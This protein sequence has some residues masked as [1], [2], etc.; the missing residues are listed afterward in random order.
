MDKQYQ[1]KKVEAKIYSFWEKK[2]FFS[3]SKSKKK[4]S[5]VIPPPN[6]TGSLHMGHAL[7]TIIQDVLIRWK[8]MEGLKTIWVPAIDHAG[9]ATQN[10][11][12]KQLKKEGKTRFDLGREKF[13]KRVWKWK[14]E[15]GDKILKQLKKFGASCDWSRTRFTM[16]KEYTQAVMKAFSHYYDKGWIYRKKRVVNWCPRCKT[17]LSDLEVE[18]KEEKGKLW[19]IKYLLVGEKEK[20]L[21]VATTRPETLLGDTAV[22]V[23]PKD[24]R[25]K[26]LVGKKV[27]LPIVNKEIPVIKDFAVDPKFGTGVV[28]I[29]PAHDLKDYQVSQRH[30]LELVQVIDEDGRLNENAPASYRG[31]KAKEAREK[32]IEDLNKSNLIEKTEDYLHQIPICYRCKFLLEPLPS[33][34]W[35][36]KMDKLAEMAKKAIRSKK[37]RFHPERW[38]RVSLSWLEE[39]ND[40]CISRQIWWGHRIPVWYCEN[41]E[42]SI[43]NLPL[44]MGFAGDIIPQVFDNK[45]R[46]Y[47]IRDYNF[48]KGDKVAFIDRSIGKTFGFGIITESVKTTV[49]KLDLKDKKHW[50]AYNSYEELIAA[51]KRHFPDREIK[52]STPVCIYTYKF[53][54]TCEPFVS[55]GTAPSK[56]R[57]CGSKKLKQVEDVFDTWFSSALWPFV[58]FGWPGKV[59]DFYPTDTLSTARDIIFLW[60]ARMIFSGLE[61]TKEVPFRDVIVHAIVLTKEGKRMSKSLGTGIDPLLLIDEYGADATR[62]G[63]CWQVSPLQ[64]IKFDGTKVVA[65]KK[66]CNKLWNASRFVLANLEGKFDLKKPKGKT[67]ADKKILSELDKIIQKTDKNLEKYEFGKA[68]QEN[69]H[70]FWSKFCDVYIEKSKGQE[71]KETEKVL[72]YVLATSL[73]LLHPFLPFITEEIY[74]RLP[75]KKKKPLIIESWPG[76]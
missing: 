53:Q 19:F 34:Q 4:Y 10:V 54:Q 60:V 33:K 32:I 30:K 36:L 76:K 72:F 13:I 29:T 17:S 65:G 52:K 12:E 1:P 68:L 46:T 41:S 57:S 71:G 61:F 5:I 62:F 22:A 37:V 69:Y 24:K 9:I 26:D 20:Y 40:W 35:F 27:V 31:L 43:E 28:K 75:L 21:L 2:K 47:R 59:N 50:K 74:S 45:T 7:N 23:N 56:C 51:F 11:V 42:L 70:F 48:K 14:E 66:F 6:I 18:Y 64:D 38:G 8:R 67:P 55:S 39:V 73:K 49:G 15:T 25:Y 63:I 3:P 58:A 16:D 44:K